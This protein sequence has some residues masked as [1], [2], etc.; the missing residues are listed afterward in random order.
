MPLGVQ[1]ASPWFTEERLLAVARW[2]EKVLHVVL[3]PPVG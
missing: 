3:T 2:C 1:L